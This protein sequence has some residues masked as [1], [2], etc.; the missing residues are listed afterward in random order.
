MIFVRR[1]ALGDMIMMTPVIR[2]YKKRNPHE[3]IWIETLCVEAFKNNPYVYHASNTKHGFTD[4]RINLNGCYEKD[5]NEHPVFL[6]AKEAFGNEK[7]SSGYKL[8]IFSD[9]EDYDFI[10]EQ[11]FLL[12]IDR[13]IVTCH[14]GRNW[15]L[16]KDEILSSVID[17]LIECGYCVI[18]LGKGVEN[19]YKAPDK[20]VI[21][22]IG[23]NLSLQQIHAL[24]KYSKLF[25]GTDTGISHV[26]F[27]S[28]IPA[29]VFYGFVSPECRR[30]IN[31]IPFLGIKGECELM[32]CAEKIKNISPNGDFTGV[33]CKTDY[34]CVKNLKVDAV[35]LQIESFLNEL[36]R[37]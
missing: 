29:I 10:R 19:E 15:T 24:M 12:K 34:S 5:F 32:P 4:E 30:P 36:N 2:E 9:R 16:V 17:L 26:A 22:L 8:D 3:K 21:N 6:Y 23:R 35:N 33:N 18:I 7:L 27:A 31:D 28:E 37:C 20:N 11:I 25:V 14:F 13:P 1:G